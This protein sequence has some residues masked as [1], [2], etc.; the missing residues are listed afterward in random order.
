MVDTQKSLRAL[1]ALMTAL[2]I[3]ACATTP[4]TTP[5]ATSS[6][7]T[8]IGADLKLCPGLNVANAPSVHSGRNIANF[9]PYTN[10]RGVSLL[11]APVDA[12][13]SSGFGPRRGGASRTHRGIDLYTGAP[14]TIRAAGDGTVT[15]MGV[16]SGYGYTL[17][18]NHGSGVET[19][20]AHLSRF[21]DGLAR[22][23]RVRQGDPIGRT[24]ETGNATAVHLHYEILIDGRAQ[25]PLLVGS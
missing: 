15:F 17:V 12:C 3:A 9:T 16:Q 19:L 4:S 7:P 22:G 23:V 18:I 14:R 13:F 11:R 2:F 5:R 1:A 25:N 20:Y 8:G 24:G 10:V 6:L 21:G